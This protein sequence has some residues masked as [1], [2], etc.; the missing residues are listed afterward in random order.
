MKA[1]KILLTV[2]LAVLLIV[3][4]AASLFVNN[5][6]D[7]VKTVVEDVGSDT[8]KTKVTL[9]NV[10]IKLLAGRIVLR[11]LAIANPEGFSSPNIFQLDEIIVHVDILSLLNNT[12]AIKEISIDGAD[13]T[14]EQ[15]AN[16]TNVKKLLDNVESGTSSPAGDDESTPAA[17]E[18]ILIKVE[19]FRLANSTARI[20]T[21][22]WG[23]KELVLKEIELLNIGGEKGVPAS[24]LAQDILR[25]IVKELQQSTE[26]RLKEIVKEKA[27]ERLKEKTDA[28]K[29]KIKNTIDSAFGEGSVDKLKSLFGK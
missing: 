16:S 14:A 20:V 13:I 11:D 3:G 10:D 12:V 2:I 4:I 1:V 8:L 21:E 25:P 19:K 28:A 6:N 22:Q 26:R 15:K 18:K 17:T 29:D 23:E 27:K 5:I 7:V 9:D 24:Q